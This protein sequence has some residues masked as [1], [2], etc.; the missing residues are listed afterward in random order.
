MTARDR[1]INVVDSGSHPSPR[2]QPT[3]GHPGCTS[4]PARVCGLLTLA[5]V[6]P[7]TPTPQPLGITRQTVPSQ[8]AVKSDRGIR[9]FVGYAAVPDPTVE[10]ERT[11]QPATDRGRV[12]SL[13]F[14][15]SGVLLLPTDC[16]RG[17]DPGAGSSVLLTPRTRQRHPDRGWRW[18]FWTDPTTT[19]GP[20]STT[21]SEISSG[22]CGSRWAG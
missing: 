20:G 1:L 16:R 11:R 15:D 19:P 18:H 6:S 10:C 9:E 8:G 3:N 2:R 5:F 14:A 22:R 21:K 7:T 13:G 4:S 12:S 17:Y